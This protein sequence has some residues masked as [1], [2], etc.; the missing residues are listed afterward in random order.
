MKISY[1]CSELI[2]EAQEDIAEFGPDAKVMV[3]FRR[4]PEYNAQFVVNYD[5]ITEDDPITGDE[6]GENETLNVLTLGELLKSL[7]EQ[8]K[9]L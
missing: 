8:N 4:S 1:E 9:I 3:W 2:A 5:F 7:Q 6:V